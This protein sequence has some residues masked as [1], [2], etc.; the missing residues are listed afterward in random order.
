MQD[1]NVQYD[2]VLVAGNICLHYCNSMRDECSADG[3]FLYGFCA[4]CGCSTDVY[5]CSDWMAQPPQGVDS[6]IL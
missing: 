2:A 1:P 4:E 6:Y 5:E 3:F